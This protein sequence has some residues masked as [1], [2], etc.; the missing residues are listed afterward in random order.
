MKRTIKISN[1]PDE[2]FQIAKEIAE[3]VNAPYL[4]GLNGE[5]GTG[6]TVFA[7]GF[8][9]GL[10]VKELVTSPTFLG[11][12][13]SY[14]GRFPF[15]HMDFYKKVVSKKDIKPY[16]EKKSIVLIEWCKNYSYVFNDLLNL[17]MSVYIQYVKD[18]DKNILENV[19]QIIIER[20][21]GV[22]GV[23]L[24]KSIN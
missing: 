23:I 21:A 8:A 7:K 11:V 3:E 17:D 2:T 13:E 10:K 5:L 16:L 19:R 22:K 14:S 1:S 12:S 18:N 9:E 4:I 20:G 24:D 15:I 6:K